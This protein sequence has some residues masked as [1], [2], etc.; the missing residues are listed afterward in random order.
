MRRQNHVLW[1]SPSTRP[2]LGGKEDDDNRLM[3]DWMDRDTLTINNAGV[4]ETACVD[5][6]LV[7]LPVSAVVQS[8]L[9]HRTRAW[10]LGSFGSA[11]SQPPPQQ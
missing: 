8:S 5:I 6:A 10:P 9:V 4:Y 11:A 7:S 2:D 3:T 1:V